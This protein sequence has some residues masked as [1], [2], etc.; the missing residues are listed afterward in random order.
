MGVGFQCQPE[1]G[2]KTPYKQHLMF[3]HVHILKVCTID[4]HLSVYQ[5]YGVFPICL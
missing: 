3:D 2:E 4:M 5:V 1:Q